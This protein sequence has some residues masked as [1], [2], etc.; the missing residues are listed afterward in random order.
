MYDAIINGDKRV[1]NFYQYLNKAGLNKISHGKLRLI[2]KNK[3]IA[4]N[5][6]AII[7]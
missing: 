4:L 3:I 6:S 7:R 1:S 5:Q 2:N